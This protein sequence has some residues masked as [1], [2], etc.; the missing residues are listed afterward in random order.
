M[1]LKTYYQNSSLGYNAL[2]MNYL[3]LYLFFVIE[4]NFV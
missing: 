2:I 4:K 3:E 1:C